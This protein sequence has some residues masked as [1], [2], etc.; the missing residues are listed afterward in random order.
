MNSLKK[1][2]VKKLLI[3]DKDKGSTVN[4]KRFVG[5]LCEKG[6][7][8]DIKEK[9]PRGF[10]KYEALLSYRL[11]K[12]N[13]DRYRKYGGYYLESTMLIDKELWPESSMLK[14]LECILL[15]A[16]LD[17]NIE[18]KIEE[19]RSIDDLKYVSSLYKSLK[20]ES[21]EISINSGWND[22]IAHNYWKA[23]ENGA[24]YYN[25][26]KAELTL[27]NSINLFINKYQNEV[28]NTDNLAG[29]TKMK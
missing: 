7:C 29:L 9:L 5:L 26:H 14:I 15:N 28:E 3:I 20:K 11:T 27:Y 22:S 8:F 10:V 17:E 4:L 16:S 18:R 21:S 1:N 23:L 2:K 6:I 25:D 19:S 24:T 13:L 12:S